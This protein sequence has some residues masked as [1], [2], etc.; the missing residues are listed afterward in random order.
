MLFAVSSSVAKVNLALTRVARSFHL[1][2]KSIC[3]RENSAGC[4]KPLCYSAT[5][6][7]LAYL[8]STSRT[9]KLLTCLSSH[10][11]DNTSTLHV[12][13]QVH[14]NYYHRPQFSIHLGCANLHNTPGQG[15]PASRLLPYIIAEPWNNGKYVV[16]D[17]RKNLGTRTPLRH[18]AGDIPLSMS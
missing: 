5:Y 18:R 13:E 9:S 7:R 14:T 6:L 15:M 10:T 11:L 1:D 3:A 12:R 2:N 8:T 4:G 16:L 17:K